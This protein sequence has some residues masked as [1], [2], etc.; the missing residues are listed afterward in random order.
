MLPQNSGYSLKPDA[1]HPCA[2]AFGYTTF[3]SVVFVTTGDIPISTGPFTYNGA[4]NA[5]SLQVRYQATDAAAFNNSKLTTTTNNG[6][7]TATSNGTTSTP[8][9]RADPRGISSGAKA[10][11]GVGVALI[12]IF[13]SLGAWMLFRLRKRRSFQGA[14]TTHN[15]SIGQEA[16]FDVGLGYLQS[17]P[18]LK[19]T[20]KNASKKTRLV[21]QQENTPRDVT[22]PEIRDLRATQE[23]W[24]SVP[25]ITTEG[26]LVEDDESVEAIQ[27]RLRKVKEERERLATLGELSRLQAQ[28]EQR[29]AAKRNSVP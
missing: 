6:S 12:L 15:R 2:S 10:G 24:H 11:I 4:V 25:N 16:H 3:P 20:S 19:D 17:K 23:I 22:Q 14:S 8:M 1:T 9:T 5:F 21:Y 26:S 29:L 13:L 18:E 7:T 27:E 28:L